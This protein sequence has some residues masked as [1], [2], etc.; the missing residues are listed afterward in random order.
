MFCAHCG[1]ELAPNGQFCQGCGKLSEVLR[2]PEPQSEEPVIKIVMP[3]PTFSGTRKMNWGIAA[4]LAAGVVMMLFKAPTAIGL[5]FILLMGIIIVGIPVLTA[6]AIGD[7]DFSMFGIY[8]SVNQTRR[9]KFRR[10][11]LALN[12]MLGGFGIIGLGACIATKQFGPMLSM[13]FYLLP[14][15]INIKALRE[16]KRFES[17]HAS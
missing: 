10:A 15:F 16:L 2:T 14:P 11:S 4:L 6:V 17:D 7:E 8:L 9:R 3:P 13:L 1:T 12:W 5:V